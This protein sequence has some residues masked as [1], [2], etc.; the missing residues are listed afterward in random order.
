MIRERAAPGQTIFAAWKTCAI[1][2]APG[3]IDFSTDNL[4]DWM[5][6]PGHMA[7][8]GDVVFSTT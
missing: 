6:S 5:N 2:G 4:D 3:V 7:T 1:M 8:L